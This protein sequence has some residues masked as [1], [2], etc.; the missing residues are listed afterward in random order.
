MLGH[1]RHLLAAALLGGAGLIGGQNGFST[2]PAAPVTPG[3]Q[4]TTSPAP[5]TVRS[6]RRDRDPGYQST[7]A[8]R[9][10]VSI[11]VYNQNFGL[12]R[13]VR[14]VPFTRGVASL[15]YRDVAQ[16]VQPE[17]VHIRPLAGGLRVL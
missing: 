1:T 4:A 5:D 16:H 14:D 15:E 13:E 7:S 8:D 3:V 12:V 6:K 10:S 9:K 11:T 17:T 2:D